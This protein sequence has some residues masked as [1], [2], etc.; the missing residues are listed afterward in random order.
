MTINLDLVIETE[1]DS[2]D[3]KAGLDSMQGVSDAVRC[4]AETILTENIPKRQTHKSKVRTSLKKSFKGSYGHIFSIDIYDPDILKK[5]SRIG[6]PAF[7]ELIAYFISESLYKESNQLSSKAQKVVD[8]L[9]DKAEELVKQLRVSSLENIHEISTK[10]NHDIKVRYRKSRDSQTVIAKF[11]RNTAKVLQAK[12]SDEKYDLRIIVTRLNIHTGNGRLQIEGADE[13]VAFGFGIGYREVNI[14]AK[15][16]FSE[17]LD[18]NN[19]ISKE[20]WKY[21]R[22]SVSPI[23]LRDGKIVKY[24]VKGFYED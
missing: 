7:I 16:L 22:I 4:A 9:G 23:K 10:F 6:R 18:H 2:V 5:L 20:K 24:I 1:E 11:D 12:Q 13:T 21:L 8:D 14:K 3:M 15:K 19:G 17:N